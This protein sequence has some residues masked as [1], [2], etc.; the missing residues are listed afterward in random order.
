VDSPAVPGTPPPSVSAAAVSSWQSRLFSHLNRYKRYPDSARRRGVE[1]V[2]Q[3]RFVI[4]GS[5]RVLSHELVTGSG[6]AA[7]D[8]A[9]VEMIRRAQPLPPPPAEILTNGRLEIV[10]PIV[11]SLEG[12]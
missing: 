9:T 3:L 8:R 11:Y 6:S 7:L 1:G 10:A 12:R 5:G 2:N 4:D